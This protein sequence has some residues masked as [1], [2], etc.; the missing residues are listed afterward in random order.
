MLENQ[1]SAEVSEWRKLD[2]GLSLG[3]FTLAERS[4]IC[5][6][7]LVI[8]KIDPNIYSLKLFSASEKDRK[9]RTTKQWCEE[10][11]LV[12]AINASMYQNM[13]MQ[14]STG[15]MRNYD[16]TNNSYINKQFGSFLVFNPKDDSLPKAQI[17]D[18]RSHVGWEELIDKYHSVVQNY[19]MISDGK[20]R[21]W[22]QREQIYSMAAVGIDYSGNILFILCRSPF[23]THDFIN[24]LLS[25]PIKIKDAMYVEGGSES[26]LSY[27]EGEKRSIYRDCCLRTCSVLR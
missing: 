27:T 24:I 11:N 26:V 25:L 16:H 9:S 5:N 18:R 20:K 22:P 19:R 3:E 1:S 10:F 23:S 13:D 21:G 6:Q 14:K 15:Y 8:L 7:K 12:A 17:I 4:K 2:N